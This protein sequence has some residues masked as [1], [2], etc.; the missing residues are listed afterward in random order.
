MILSDLSI[1]RPVFAAVLMLALV[2]LGIFSYRRLSVEMFPSVEIPVISIVT[3]FP[4]ASPESI[5]REVSKKIEEA[6]NQIAGVK[7]VMSFSR[8]GVSTVMVE[9]RLE[10][11]I[12]EVSQEARAK[13]NGIRGNL[14]TTI[15]D[16]IIQKLDFNALPVASIAVKAKGMSPKDLTTLVEKKVKRRLENVSGVGKV[17]L[18]GSTKREVTVTIDPARLDALGLGIDTVVAGL[19]SENVNTPLGRLTH[20]GNE[21][22]IRI[23]GKPDRVEGFRNMVI[24][25]RGG[26]GIALSEVADVSDGAKEQRSL[27]LINGEPAVALDILKQSGANMVEV[28]DG[29]K[30]SVEKLKKDLPPGVELTMVRDASIPTRESL[31][32]VKETM[33]IGGLLT[34][35]IVFCFI[36]SWRSTVIT[37][38][39]LPI[40]VISSFIIMNAMGMTLNVM[41]LMALSLAI[42]LLIDDAIVVRENIVRHLEHGQDHITASRVGTSEIGLAVFATSMSIIAVFVPVAFMRGI[43]GRFFFQFGMTVA[44]AVLVSLFVSFT[45]DPMLSSR[46]HDPA[47]ALKGRRKGLAKLLDHFNDRFD[48]WADKYQKAISWALGHRKSVLGLAFASFVAGI[49]I[50]GTLESSFMTNDDKAEFQV[51]FKTAPDASISESSD[52]LKTILAAVSG[53]PEV[54]HTYASIGAGDNGTVRQGSLYV[55]LK[56]KG[57]RKRTQEQVQQEFR[58]RLAK[59]PGITTSI[60]RVGD[61]GGAQKPL[62]VNLKGEDIPTLK[63][64]AAQLRKELYQIPGLVDLEMTLDHD[65]PEYR[66]TV[67]RQRAQDAGVNTNDIASTVSR[68]VGGEA[69]ST[70][71]DEDGDAVDV[72]VRLPES[73]RR[74]PGQVRDLKLAVARGADTTLVPLG[75]LTRYEVS[76][77][78]SEI[79]RRDLS[80]LVTISANLDGIPIGTAVAKVKEAAAKVPMQPGYSVGFSGEAEDMAESFGYMAESLIIAIVFVYLILAA[81]FE[82]FLEPMAIMLS[83]P[84]SIVGMAGMLKLTGDTVNIMSLIGLIMLMGLVTKNAILL[85]DYAKVLQQRGAN[86]FDAVVEA[87]RTRL[88]PI[89]MTT[90][91]MIFGMMPLFFALGSGAEMRAPMARAVVG[92][93]LTSTLLTL[94]VVPVMYTVLDDFQVWLKRKWKGKEK[95]A[96][97]AT[98][99]LV[100]GVALSIGLAPGVCSAAEARTLTLDQAMA[101]AMDQNRD[102][103]KARAYA[104]LVH[105]R[106]LEERAAALP[107]LSL[108]GSASWSNDD[109]QGALLGSFSQ[110][111][112]G[113]G[114]GSTPATVTSTGTRGVDLRLTQTLFNWGKVGAA[115]R[116]ASEGLKTAEDQ[117]R[118]YQQAARRDVS[119]AFYDVL[120]AKELRALA[121][122]NLQQKERHLAE[123]QRR[124][125]AGVATDYDVLAAQVGVANAR[126]EVIRGDNRIKTAKERLRLVLALDQNDLDVGGSLESAPVPLPPFE[127][128]LAVARRLRPELSDLRHRVGIS[129]ELV[130]IAKAGNKPQLDL[131]GGVGWHQFESGGITSDGAAWDIGLY[132]T[133]PF[134]DGL[135]TKGKVE[136]AESDLRTRELDEAQQLDAV[137]LQV[138]DAGFGVTE[139]EEIVTALGGTVKQA[140]RLLAMAEQGY[141]LGVKTR[142]EVED[143][144]TNLVQARGNLAQAR[145]D[146]QVALVNLAWSTGVLGER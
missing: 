125:T 146:Y 103:Q 126:P 37:G 31:A 120:L 12:N 49:A 144:E 4:G 48:A 27:A 110:S 73:L 122:S 61:V 43:V 26:R 6:V 138:R 117:L 133:F 19:K 142:L 86:R 77:T 63:R 145:R 3:K 20:G 65:I 16:P 30:K 10:E 90:L 50:F 71:E 106:Y 102:I 55:K 127:E 136:Q 108:T 2:T 68:L 66:M 57:E 91:A 22:P 8:E 46:W 124:L 134:F 95:Q 137:S 135:K 33:L 74:N 39:T 114:V 139:A 67:D 93:L 69:V 111:A 38:L 44:F 11:K 115:I 34:V 23:A 96:A 56:E 75:N 13:I 83:L 100:A 28:V 118:L 80:R 98:L 76:N 141:E 15:E 116:G 47:I 51:G 40:S 32:D 89:V 113:T 42:G 112:G 62:Q 29:V 21:Y 7:H 123:A 128:S 119:V 53:V 97:T 18:V 17:D 52:R 84:L 79:N 78:P 92:G 87:G 35:I 107:S 64:Y 140:E 101:I 104:R 45:L 9:F 70:Y 1:K 36:N 5:E 81:Q 54:E 88:R 59:I 131:R 24:A 94:L 72:R 99:L 132:L 109:S 82:S 25:Q 143:A 60:E 41:T 129:R 105:G 130:Q 14:P 121:L 85:V 58:S